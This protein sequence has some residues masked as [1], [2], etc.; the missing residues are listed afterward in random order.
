MK[1]STAAKRSGRPSP[2]PTSSSKDCSSPTSRNGRRRCFPRC[3]GGS[4]LRRVLLGSRS[5]ASAIHRYDPLFAEL[6]AE[7]EGD[8]FVARL[9]A[10]TG[11]ADLRADPSRD[12]AGVHQ[13]VRGSVLDLHADFNGILAEGRT[14]Y[15]RL[16]V[17]VY[18][19]AEWRDDRDGALELYE[20]TCSRVEARIPCRFNT[21][22]IVEV[23]DRRTTDTGACGRRAASRASASSPT[24]TRPNRTRSRL[25]SGTTP[26]SRG[27]PTS[28]RSNSLGA[29]SSAPSSSG[30]PACSGCR[31][32]GA[33][34]PRPRALRRTA[35]A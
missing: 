20:R 11:I 31:R 23:H 33:R 26:R 35:G 25:A 28:R 34:Y 10:L 15:R 19:S 30:S 29:G 17:I 7:L 24:T 27:R 1:S 6:F 13:G 3:R 5:F 22:L 18:V 2:S 9:R 4:E 14:L 12:G 21:A 32:Q 16:N 8:A